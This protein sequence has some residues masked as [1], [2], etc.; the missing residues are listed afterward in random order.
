MKKY[1]SVIISLLYTSLSFANTVDSANLQ[2]MYEGAKEIEMLNRAMEAGMRE[3]NAP[4]KPLLI[5]S[6]ES[7][8]EST[9]IEGFQEL[10]KTFYLQRVIED[11]QSTKLEVVLGENSLKIVTKTTKKEYIHTDNGISE[12]TFES[13]TT[14]ELPLPQQSDLSTFRKN[15]KEGILEI[16]IDKKISKQ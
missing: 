7:V 12:S 8:I 4:S 10:E 5:E 15:Y 2:S 14:E 1:A 16:F 6:S 11:P 9:P 3:H 13:S